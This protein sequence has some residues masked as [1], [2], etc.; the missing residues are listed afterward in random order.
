[1]QKP[2]T[3]RAMRHVP[4]LLHLLFYFP[5]LISLFLSFFLISCLYF[6]TDPSALLLFLLLPLIA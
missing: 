6:L 4:E 3:D 5:F 2:V 1:M